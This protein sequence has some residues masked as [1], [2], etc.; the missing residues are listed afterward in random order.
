M[1]AFLHS[2]HSCAKA[3]MHVRLLL[4]QELHN[5][6]LD[7]NKQILVALLSAVSFAQPY[8]TNT[9]YFSGGTQSK[10]LRRRALTPA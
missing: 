5:R 3:H 9:Q 4:D 10:N 7:P 8:L 2:L 6:R 1:L